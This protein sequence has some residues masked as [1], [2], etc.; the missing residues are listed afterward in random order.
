MKN[1]VLN[2]FGTVTAIINSYFTDILELAKERRRRRK[3][4]SL[5]LKRT[6]DLIASFAGLVVF[7]PVILA[8]GIIVKS[9]SPGPII[10][11]QDRV[12]INNRIF[13]MYKIRT[14]RANAESRTGPVWSKRNDPRVVPFGAFLR[15][16]HIDELPQ[17]F[18]VLKGEMSLVGPR[19][20]RPEIVKRF[21]DAFPKYADRVTVKPGITGY[22]QIRH[23][24]DEHID[25][26]RTKLKYELF[27]IKKICFLVDMSILLETLVIVMQGKDHYESKIGVMANV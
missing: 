10:Y 3:S 19:P 23:K 9:N 5:F 15:M 24:Y 26:V 14:M 11:K 12:G 27:Y 18:N 21:K 1:F 6:F 16:S 4:F 17:L 25:D 2:L 8:S 22:A 20:E 13:T 7:F